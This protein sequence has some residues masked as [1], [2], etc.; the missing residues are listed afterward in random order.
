MPPGY[1]VRPKFFCNIEKRI[2]SR[3]HI[4]IYENN[5]SILFHLFYFVKEHKKLHVI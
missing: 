1:S 5:S 3:L 4:I 2:F